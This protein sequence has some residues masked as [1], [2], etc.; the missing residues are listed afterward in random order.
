MC[1]KL[2]VLTCLVA[3]V[4]WAG[5][6]SANSWTGATDSSWGTFGNW[7]GVGFAPTA[8]DTATGVGSPSTD[9]SGAAMS[10][11]RVIQDSGTVNVTGQFTLARNP[12]NDSADIDWRSAQGTNT[13]T[14][15]ISGSGELDLQ[16]L[17]SASSGRKTR[18]GRLII[19]DFNNG[20]GIMNMSGNATVKVGKLHLSG[21]GSSGRL[22]MSD[23]ALM[24]VDN[25]FFHAPENP[26]WDSLI[27][28]GGNARVH[29]MPFI[30]DGDGSVSNSAGAAASAEANANGKV[31]GGFIVGDD[32][33]GASVV[34]ESFYDASDPDVW[35]Y[36]EI[37]TPEPSSLALLGVAGLALTRISRRKRT[38]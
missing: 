4:G 29:L 8:G 2:C 7:D 17:P 3:V 36:T 31:A 12:S 11:Y 26:A 38:S 13:A 9:M 10:A 18:L 24:Q 15:N 25:N 32:G 27:T 1:R 37:R 21:G 5:T 35:L 6:A 20:A 28:L 19:G 30:N 16:G 23:N 33:T 22:N 34:V 14:I